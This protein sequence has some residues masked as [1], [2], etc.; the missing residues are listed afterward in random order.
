MSWSKDK[1]RALASERG[2][3]GNDGLGR[4][5]LAHERLRG[6]TEEDYPRDKAGKELDALLERQVTPLPRETAREYPGL[7]QLRAYT[8]DCGLSQPSR[9]ISTD[10]ENSVPSQMP[11]GLGAVSGYVR[12]DGERE[13]G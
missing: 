5:L 7:K 6:R 9:S 13:P 8:A 10:K 1:L 2:E 3:T 11:R 4:L 12:K